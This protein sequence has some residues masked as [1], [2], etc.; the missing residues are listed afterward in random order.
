MSKRLDIS[1]L[2][3]VLAPSP[4]MLSFTV[5][6]LWRWGKSASIPLSS[7]GSKTNSTCDGE[8]EASASG[9]DEKPEIEIEK[10]VLVRKTTELASILERREDVL[11]RL[12]HAHIKVSRP[13]FVVLLF[14]GEHVVSCSTCQTISRVTQ[15]TTDHQICLAREQGPARC[16]TQN[17]APLFP[18]LADEHPAWRCRNF[19]F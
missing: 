7:S 19:K 12:E 6:R 18:S 8:K 9:T 10:V 14:L 17:A 2:A 1:P 5:N 3:P 16:Q 4:G 15:A 11:R 13:P